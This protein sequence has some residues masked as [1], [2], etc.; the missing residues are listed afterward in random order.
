LHATR[1]I[2][3][4]IA[5]TRREFFLSS[6]VASS[7][8][9]TALHAAAPLSGSG[10]LLGE[11]VRANDEAVARLLTRQERGVSH[12]SRGG[13]P[14]EFGIYGPHEA[15]G[16][17]ST[18]V[19]SHA[20]R[21]SKYHH[22]AEL[23][24]PLQLA[25]RFLRKVQHDD[26]TIDL[27]STNFHSTPDLAFVFE[28]I[29]AAATILKNDAWPQ[30]EPLREELRAF[31]LK[32]G[33]A[34]TTGGIHTPNH[35]WVVCAG[36][37]WVHSL[38]PNQKYVARVDQWLAETIDVDP[39]GQYTEK[40]TT[41]YSP[42]VNRALITVARLLNRP[43]LLEPVRRN[44]EMTLFYVHPDGEVVTEAS[45]RQDKYQRG[46]M[47]RYYYSYRYLALRDG[48][49]RFAAMARQIEESA[50]GKLGGELAAFLSDPALQKP[51][52]A[53]AALPTNYE[54]VF[55][56]SGLA[57][58]R[59]EQASGTI[60]AGN[61]TLLSFRKGAAALEA[62][63][64]ASAF[65]G[66]GQLVGNRLE[67]SNGRYVLRQ[68]LAGPYF[69]PLSKDQVADGE[70]VKMAP[71]GTLA[72]NSRAARAQSNIQ[73]LESVATITERNGAF[74]VKLEITGTDHV[75]VAI[76]L[77]F[78]HGGTLRG[79]EPVNDVKDAFLLKSGSG[80][81]TFGN[82][83]ITFGPGRTEH[84]WTQLR[85]ALPKWD[86]Q[87]VYLTGFTPFNATIRIA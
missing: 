79:V 55:A 42:I 40:S 61:S 39:D 21:G 75:P 17:I 24:E 23:I 41:V 36:L 48:N 53:S 26:G 85:G 18:L 22:S 51:L 67:A 77:A 44:L 4:L 16:F 32:G 15:A 33:E 27:Y 45:T 12:P 76:E 68:S 50:R 37:A 9:T 82:Q 78:R 81:Y 49:G 63:R 20:A 54:K 84:T 58:I 28:V 19:A 70:H 71:N 56:H 5:V 29:G 34:L 7:L 47:G 64:V 73:T 13:L 46:S 52:P 8:A 74:E 69:Q 86:G 1:F 62:F 59:R 43:A 72:T 80:E 30:H 38:Y 83:T 60:L 11:L 31:M 6:A 14:N 3:S 66:K 65:F 25:A 10:D 35:R 87:S 2:S 57:R